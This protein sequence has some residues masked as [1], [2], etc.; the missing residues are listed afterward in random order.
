MISIYTIC[1]YIYICI[2]VYMYRSEPGGILDGLWE[3]HR[4]G[5]GGFGFCLLFFDFDP[6]FQLYGTQ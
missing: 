6:L 3:S 4:V 1:I 2:Y 5:Y